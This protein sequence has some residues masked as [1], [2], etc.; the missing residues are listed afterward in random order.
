MDDFA[1]RLPVAGLTIGSGAGRQ[2]RVAGAI[3]Q[4]EHYAALALRD[5]AYARRF[6]GGVAALSE[7]DRA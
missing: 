1:K 7:T 6:P 2:R 3:N 5:T 4:S